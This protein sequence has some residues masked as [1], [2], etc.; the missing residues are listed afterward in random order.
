MITF[1]EIEVNKKD[2]Y[3]AKKPIEISKVDVSNTIVFE[4]LQVK[5]GFKCLIGYLVI[6]TYFRLF[7]ERYILKLRL[8]GIEIFEKSLGS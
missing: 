3:G 4:L 6:R 8:N 7:L 5:K 1:A 2:I